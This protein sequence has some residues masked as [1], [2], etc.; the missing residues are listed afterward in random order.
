MEIFLA[1]LVK[2]RQL[3]WKLWENLQCALGPSFGLCSTLGWYL[4]GV[5]QPLSAQA[6]FSNC[7]LI[8]LRRKSLKLELHAL[9]I[10]A[11]SFIYLRP[12]TV[13]KIGS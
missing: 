2:V 11:Q 4:K 5:N 9:P 12:V 7:T 3:A 10:P 13:G 8:C 1:S 6:S